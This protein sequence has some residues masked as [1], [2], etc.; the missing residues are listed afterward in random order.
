MTVSRLDA[1][2]R[3]DPPLSVRAAL[4]S[5]RGHPR[6]WIHQWNWK[7]ALTSALI[8]GTLFFFVNLTAS[9]AA[10]YSALLTELTLRAFTSGFYGSVT[11]RFSRV[12]PRW[13][14]TPGPGGSAD[15]D[16]VL[17]MLLRYSNCVGGEQ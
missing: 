16:A 4:V 15:D 6:E 11:Q 14:G 2:R 13:A 5:L 7:T 8:R 10:A 17:D 9:A 3:S 1:N 12:E